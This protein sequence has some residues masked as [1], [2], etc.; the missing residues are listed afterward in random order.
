MQ[1]YKDLILKQIEKYL[2]I[3]KI[4]H[5]HSGKI[6]MVKCPF[7]QKEPLTANIIPNTSTLKCFICKKKYNL[8]DIANKV[9]EQ[10]RT[11]EEMLTYLRDLL[12]V[13]IMTKTDIDT[14]E[15]FLEFYQEN[16]FDLVPI[17][18]NGKVPIEQGWTTKK[19]TDSAEWHQWV[20]NGL[21]LGVKTGICSNITVID[22]DALTKP[23]KD[24]IRNGI[25]TPERKAELL[26]MRKERLTKVYKTLG[27]IGNPLVQSNLGG[28]HL[29][30]LYEE[31]LPKSFVKVEGIHL[32][33]ENDGGYILIYPSKLP[34]STRSFKTLT[35]LSIQ[36]MPETLLKLL[37]SKTTKPTKTYSENMK[38]AIKTENFK[39]DPKD[40]QLKDDNLEG[41][42]N[43]SFIKLGGIFRKQ[44][45]IQQTSYVLHT[46]NR[47]LLERPMDTKAINS[48]LQSIDRYS[49]FDE[50]ALA[51]EIIKYLKDVKE[52]NRTEISMTVMGTNR[53]EDKK[54]VDKAL[55]YLVKEE[56]VT[57]RGAKYELI[58][59]MNWSGS[60][61]N[62][63]IPI[64]FKMPYFH[65]W[66]HL[67]QEDLIIIGSQNKY[68]KTT[69]A[70]NIVKRL[71]DQGITPDYIYNES[72]GRY[73]KVA[74]KL[75]MKDDDFYAS[76][77][78]NP[79]KIIL[80]KN[81]IVIFDWVKP[82]DFARTD[83]LFSDLVEKVKKSNGFL[84][85]F[86][87]LRTNNEFFAKDQIGQFPALISKYIYNDE[88]GTDTQFLLEYIREAKPKG[89]KFVIPCV[90]NWDTH[91]VKTAYELEKEQQKKDSNKEK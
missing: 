61:M 36:K 20:V 16:G 8:L 30:Y 52:A 80:R 44:L 73:A 88:E 54:R 49:Q 86:V 15:Q 68:G 18:A 51:I 63:G 89:K 55:S 71:V 13:K 81:K 31:S 2:D 56:K 9:E 17:S 26:K 76:F 47:H 11:E 29:I 85:C 70:M 90:Y 41:T 84:I 62:V 79:D 24:E 91:E 12:D 42:C 87:Q 10:K 75:G 57:K 32:D 6:I 39:I 40:L 43:T 50:E 69:V 22:I 23:E 25:A 74:L 35:K 58:E 27:D 67:N 33:I 83:S 77:C 4:F 38:E 3:K 34:N 21:N 64:K 78:S 82:N 1:L 14:I 65:D 19:H 60:L 46:L 72:G 37:K 48:M 7:C 45:T 66:V 5:R 53:G 28:E 59:E